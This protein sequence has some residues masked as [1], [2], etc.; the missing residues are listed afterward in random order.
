MNNMVLFIVA[1]CLA[2]S[3]VWAAKYAGYK[4]PLIKPKQMLAK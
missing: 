2:R 1:S 4:R 3:L